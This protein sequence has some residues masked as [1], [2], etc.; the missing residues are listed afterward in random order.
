MKPET[1]SQYSLTDSIRRQADPKT[2]D[3]TLTRESESALIKAAASGDSR[4]YVRLLAHHVGILDYHV[5]K[6]ADSLAISDGIRELQQEALEAFDRALKAYNADGPAQFKTYLSTAVRN[7]VGKE[8]K[9]LNKI[10]GLMESIHDDDSGGSQVSSSN[11]SL[12]PHVERR[13][14]RVLSRLDEDQLDA[15]LL[16]HGS[17]KLSFEAIAKE[18]GRG[19]RYYWSKTYHSGV[20][21]ALDLLHAMESSATGC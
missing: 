6:F 2:L 14:A 20:R 18:M 16:H 10:D 12:D 7:A 19:S 4:S 8:A 13:C 5:R 15:L 17:H 11:S 9:K 3:E 21:K 1:Y